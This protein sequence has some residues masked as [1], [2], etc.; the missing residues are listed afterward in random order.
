[1]GVAK[2][3]GTGIRVWKIKLVA[4]YVGFE[5]TVP[6]FTFRVTN[7]TPEFLKM[8]PSGKVSARKLFFAGVLVWVISCLAL[9]LALISSILNLLFGYVRTIKNR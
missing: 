4:D 6:P 7:K 8:N 1:M 9:I 2:L 5:Y 3:W